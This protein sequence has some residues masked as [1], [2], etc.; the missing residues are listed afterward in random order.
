VSAMASQRSI[1]PSVEGGDCYLSRVPVH[2]R[3]TTDTDRFDANLGSFG[4]YWGVR[5]VPR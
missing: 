4:Q 1:M 3:N 5:V 2:L